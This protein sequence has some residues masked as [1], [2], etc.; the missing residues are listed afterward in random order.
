MDRIL[1]AISSPAALKPLT[2]EELSILAHEIR[3]QI[4][5]TARGSVWSAVTYN[6]VSGYVMTG[7]L[8]FG[9]SQP[10]TTPTPTPAS[11][12]RRVPSICTMQRLSIPTSIL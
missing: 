11:T 10:V 8:D 6:G 3:T 1:D 4:V 7:Y 2:E 9:A 12:R 5:V